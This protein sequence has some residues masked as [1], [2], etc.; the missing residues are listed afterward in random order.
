MMMVVADDQPSEDVA[1]LMMTDDGKG[2]N[3]KIPSFMI[4]YDDANIIKNAIHEDI[5]KMVNSDLVKEN[6]EDFT[7][8]EQA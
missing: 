2:Q 4:S 6:P 3:V 5:A 8:E 1:S 7:P